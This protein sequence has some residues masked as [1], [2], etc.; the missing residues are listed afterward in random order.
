MTRLMVRLKAWLQA[1][2]D[3]FV[4]VIVRIWRWLRVLW[5]CRVPSLSALGGGALLLLVP[6]AR[7]LFADTGFGFF[8]WFW[9]FV[10]LLVWT[11]VVHIM[12][13]R[14]LQFDEWVPAAHASGGL[15]DD[16]RVRLRKEF[17]RP[18]IWIPRLLGLSVFAFVALALWIT[19][20]N[21]L[22]AIGLTQASAAAA[23]IPWLVGATVGCAA[24]Y[25]FIVIRRRS[26]SNMLGRVQ[27]P[28]LLAR[29]Q[30]IVI[31][32]ANPVKNWPILKRIFSI[33]VNAFLGVLAA[34]IIT[35]FIVAVVS[36]AFL[37]DWVPRALFLPLLLG[38][39]LLLFGEIASLS[40]RWQTPLLLLFVL[41]GGILG[42][43]LE[44]YNDVRWIAG[45]ARTAAGSAP[46]QATI[47]E[48]IAAWKASNCARTPCEVRPIVVAGSGGAS[49]AGF[50]TATV[51]GALMDASGKPG[52]VR[53]QIFALS[54][55]SGSSVGAAMMR[56]AWMD[57][58]D[59][60][61]PDR[62]PCKTGQVSAWFGG[63]SMTEVKKDANPWRDCFQKLMAGDFLSTVFVGIAYRDIFPIGGLLDPGALDRS[64]LLQ[65]AFERWYHEMVEGSA[66]G[67][68]REDVRGLCRSVGHLQM[69]PPQPQ[70]PWIPLLFING[71]SVTTGRRIIVSDI[72]TDCFKRPD[73]PFLNLSYDASELRDPALRAGSSL[74]DTSLRPERRGEVNLA[75]SSAAMMSARFPI[76]STHGAIRDVGGDGKIV[77]TVVDGGYFENDGLA[78][79]ADIVRELMQAELKPIVVKITNDP[80]SVLLPPPGSDIRP[81]LPRYEG[82]TLFDTYTSIGRALYAT[83]S[84]HEDGHLDYL[85]GTL[86]G[87]P[88]VEIGVGE[89]K[90]RG[91]DKDPE[92]QLCRLS[93]KESTAMDTVSMSWWMSQPVQ[94]YLD[95]Q[96]CRKQAKRLS[97]VL[98]LPAQHPQPV[99]TACPVQ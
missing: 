40:H 82:R 19:R 21:L 59:S 4:R 29:A 24:I 23:R 55:V 39:G 46:Q 54:T 67:C 18:A 20:L 61:N 12:A 9:F 47:G 16:E 25:L 17:E 48:A 53:N 57:A 75:L 34:G 78:T 92:P 89:I 94:A 72:R 42:F 58:L 38:G 99:D 37:S 30:S 22:P 83:R 95:A 36:P 15:S 49:R 43:F 97:C 1:V 50:F 86:E 6:Q 69:V 81:T 68:V 10:F 56:A 98:K 63:T 66:R 71:T 96:L 84:G 51:V 14:A 90:P 80:A 77:D 79:A 70:R 11:W 52:E 31:L 73:E 27:D 74:C 93:V 85:R 28:P 8:S 87:N 45:P 64:A 26:F 76:I 13:R 91:E 62:P 3:L 88:L 35:A 2:V 32:L 7:D 44:H 33:K 5:V 41:A 65:D 60:G